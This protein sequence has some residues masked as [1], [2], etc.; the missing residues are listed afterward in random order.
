M[1]KQGNTLNS[2]I[3]TLQNFIINTSLMETYATEL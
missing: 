1:R 2:I 3:T